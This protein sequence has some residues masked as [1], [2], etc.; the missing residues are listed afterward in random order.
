MKTTQ[1]KTSELSGVALDWAVSVCQGYTPVI[2]KNPY[3]LP[4]LV[5]ESQTYS[6]DWAYAGPIIDKQKIA[7]VFDDPLWKS[8][9]VSTPADPAFGYWYGQTALIAACRCYVASM[10]GDVVE[11]PG[12]LLDA[13]AE[14]GS[15]NISG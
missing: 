3:R 1:V 12:E 8:A 9:K 4:V 2:R 11:I 10:L 15:L 6:T 13:E 5:S 7:V 14:Q